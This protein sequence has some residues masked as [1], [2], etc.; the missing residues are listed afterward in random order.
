MAIATNRGRILHLKSM[1]EALPTT[2]R[3]AQ[4][5]QVLSIA[6][7]EVI[8]G[9]QAMSEKEEL[10]LVSQ[11][12]YLKRLPIK[13]LRGGK[14]G[15]TGAIALPLSQ[16]SDQLIAMLSAS[17]GDSVLVLTS[18]NR[19]LKLSLSTVPLLDRT[20]PGEFMTQL[21]PN[22]TIKLVKNQDLRL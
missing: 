11:Q 22:E 7:E 14:L 3:A 12:G 21:K 10:L 20:S 13:A 16:R 1:E 17:V 15:D 5:T 2:S 6:P 8:I 4:G 18:L 9:A 19:A